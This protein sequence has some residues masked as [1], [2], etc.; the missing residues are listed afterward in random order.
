MIQT[1]IRLLF[2]DTGF[3]M[4]KKKLLN[5]KALNEIDIDDSIRK[6]VYIPIFAGILI[7]LFGIFIIQS[8]FLAKIMLFIGS[9]VIG[10]SGYWQIKYKVVPG[11]PTIRGGCAVVLGIVFILAFS[12]GALVGIWA[13]V[14]DK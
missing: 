14:F 12:I 10:L 1:E 8:G 3:Y 4:K 5:T 6:H 7:S 2:I 13:V 11:M 9:F